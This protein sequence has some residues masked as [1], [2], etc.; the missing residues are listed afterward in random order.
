MTRILDFSGPKGPK[1]FDLCRMAVLSGGDGKSDR[2][3]LV[4]RKEA[5]LLDALDVVSVP[6]PT[7]ADPEARTVNGGSVAVA[8]DDFVLLEA[9][10]DAT[11]WLPRISRDVVDAQDWLS[12]AE[13]VD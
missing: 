1:R 10:M 11:P 13:K 2:S 12:A 9:Y 6:T 3:R 8:Q 5:R 4:I 7:P